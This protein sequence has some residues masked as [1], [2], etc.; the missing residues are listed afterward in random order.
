MELYIKN[1][2]GSIL[3]STGIEIKQK[4]LKK[5]NIKT[6][7]SSELCFYRIDKKQIESDITSFCTEIQHICISEGKKEIFN[8]DVKINN[9]C[10]VSFFI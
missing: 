5:L 7:D 1:K 2:I 10:V 8:L 9:E 3:K 4:L 6:S